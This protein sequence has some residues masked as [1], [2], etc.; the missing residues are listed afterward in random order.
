[1]SMASLFLS[2]V[3]GP[4]TVYLFLNAAIVLALA[5]AFW[6]IGADAETP[7]PGK[8]RGAG[9]TQ[10][11]TLIPMSRVEMRRWA[12]AGGGHAIQ[13]AERRQGG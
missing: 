10:K 12:T 6:L 8:N 9:A 13:S 7:S 2:G 3:N 4:I 11:S 5:F 1:M